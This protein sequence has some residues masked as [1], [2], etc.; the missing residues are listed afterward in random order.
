MGA[1]AAK[2]FF[3][4]FSRLGF[5]PRTEMINKLKMETTAAKSFFIIFKA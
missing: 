5:T 3:Y 4:Y 2:K 1:T